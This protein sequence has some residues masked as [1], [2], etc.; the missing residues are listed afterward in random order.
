MFHFI[1]LAMPAVGPTWSLGHKTHV[2][3]AWLT[4]RLLGR[5][6]FPAPYTLSLMTRDLQL[7]RRL[8]PHPARQL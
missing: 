7:A 4:I 8:D 6:R 2:P 3:R 1:L 5:A